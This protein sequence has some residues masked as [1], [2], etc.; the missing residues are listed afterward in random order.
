M[1]TI[2]T[3]HTSPDFLPEVVSLTGLFEI[4]NGDGDLVSYENRQ[5]CLTSVL[6]VYVVASYYNDANTGRICVCV[7]TVRDL[8]EGKLS[9]E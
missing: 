3:V 7:D 2:E 5:A 8:H 9:Y 4:I 6:D 1:S